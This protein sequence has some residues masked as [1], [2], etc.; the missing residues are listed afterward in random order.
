MNQ[1]GKLTPT[2]AI[3]SLCMGDQAFFEA[4]AHR[5][6]GL[7]ADA[8]QEAFADPAGTGLSSA[9]QKAGIP[10][11]Q[12]PVVR[13]ALKAIAD[14]PFEGD[15]AAHMQRVISRVLTQVEDIGAETLD[16][17]LAKLGTLQT[18]NRA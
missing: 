13:A 1:S 14:T 17:L 18:E 6:R 16:F 5:D 2:A 9:C 3:R 12:M 7:G 11:S 10:L 4:A 15:P 8:V